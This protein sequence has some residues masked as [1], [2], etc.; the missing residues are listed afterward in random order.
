MPSQTVFLLSILTTMAIPWARS[1][2]AFEN[3]GGT[4]VLAQGRRHKS[5]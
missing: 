3:Q 5:Q 1:L 4:A 2:N